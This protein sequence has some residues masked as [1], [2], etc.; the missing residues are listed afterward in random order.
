[1]AQP[2]SNTGVLVG[3]DRRSDPA[4]AKHYSTL[5]LSRLDGC[6]NWSCEIREVVFGVVL[7]GAFVYNFMPE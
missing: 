7:M 6:G 2:S 5:N 3:S 1:V 4:P